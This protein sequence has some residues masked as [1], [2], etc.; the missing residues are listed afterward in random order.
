MSRNYGRLIAKG[1]Y[2]LNVDDD[3]TVLPGWDQTIIDFIETDDKIVGA[4]QMGFLAFPDLSN[5][6]RIA[7]APGQLADFITGFCWGYRNLGND[8]MP[9]DWFSPSGKP[10][11]LH[12]ETWVQCL[13][14]E[15]GGKFI[16]TPV[17][18]IHDSQRGNVDF[19]DNADKI[20]KIQDTFNIQSL[21]LE[22]I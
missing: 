22:R 8:Q 21:N 9:W 12:D 16:I 10:S 4:G 5:F 1:K 7:R 3:V 18:S 14:R 13:M 15:K 19:D 20:K 2:I 11:A 6:N 17:I